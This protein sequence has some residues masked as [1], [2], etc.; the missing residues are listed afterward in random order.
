MHWSSF[1][2]PK[3]SGL[4]FSFLKKLHEPSFTIGIE[5]EFQRHSIRSRWICFACAVRNHREGQGVFERAREGGD[6]TSRLVRSRNGHLQKRPGRPGANVTELRPH[7]YQA[8]AGKRLALVGVRGQ[9][10]RSRTGVNRRIYPMS[11]TSNIVEDLEAGLARFEPHLRP[12]RSHRDRSTGDGD[13][14]HERSPVTSF[15][16]LWRSPQIRRFG[17]AWRRGE[18]VPS[19][20]GVTI[21][22][23]AQSADYFSSNGEF[24][25]FVN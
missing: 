21:N 5:E 12:A 10:I 8:G 22:S 23:P 11:G 15:A 18:I 9:R 19:I 4:R 3:T 17:W 16:H 25:E 6:C 1:L 14:D 2:S 24:D 7:H 20:T 13:P